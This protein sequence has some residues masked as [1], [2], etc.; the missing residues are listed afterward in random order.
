MVYSLTVYGVV[1][2]MAS[3]WLIDNVNGVRRLRTAATNGP[4]V[5]PPGDISAR[6][7]MVMVMRAGESS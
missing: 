1:L 2:H 3:H 7:A 6:R 5:H 4:I